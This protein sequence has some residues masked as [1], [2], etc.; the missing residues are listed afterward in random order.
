MDEGRDGPLIKVVTGD[1]EERM[2]SGYILGVEC[3]GLSE[4]VGCGPL[5]GVGEKLSNFCLGQLTDGVNS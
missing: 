3:E 2:D 5:Q 4:Y 1:G